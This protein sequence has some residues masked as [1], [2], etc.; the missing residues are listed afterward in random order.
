MA[1][2]ETKSMAPVTN[3]EIVLFRI[4][5][6]WFYVWLTKIYVLASAGY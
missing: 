5:S 2:V 6:S 4:I 1:Q 3:A